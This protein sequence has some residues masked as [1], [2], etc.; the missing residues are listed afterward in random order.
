MKKTI[1]LTKQE[2]ITSFLTSS[3]QTLPGDHKD[4]LD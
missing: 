4:D 1:Q 2:N 3:G